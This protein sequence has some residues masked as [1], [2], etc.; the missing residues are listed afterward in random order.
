MK[1][2]IEGTYYITNRK[3]KEIE[4][5][6]ETLEVKDG[7]K[8]YEIMTLMM[9]PKTSP[10]ISALRKKQPKYVGLR[11]IKLVGFKQVIPAD[12]EV[13][14]LESLALDD[15][16]LDSGGVV[17]ADQ[18]FADIAQALGGTKKKGK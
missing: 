15:D 2:T 1:V 14:T 8:D 10:L 18:E 12:E 6:E 7:L 9:E 5:F 11:K 16:D 4:G 17:T 13:D 3:I